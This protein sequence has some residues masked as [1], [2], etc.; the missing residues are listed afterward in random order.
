VVIGGIYSGLMFPSSAGAVGAIGALAIMA[1]RRR[2]KASDVLRS[3]QDAATTTAVLFLVIIAGLILSR[4]L[5]YSGF[6]DEI[7][8]WIETCTRTRCWGSSC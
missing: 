3:V 2:G 6:V 1:L 5:I 7:I 8:T 4:F